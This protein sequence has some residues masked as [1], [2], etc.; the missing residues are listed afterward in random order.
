[1]AGIE[2]SDHLADEFHDWRDHS[3]DLAQVPVGTLSGTPPEDWAALPR[4]PLSY[5]TEPKTKAEL[6]AE[7]RATVKKAGAKAA[8]AK[9]PKPA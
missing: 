8:P 2:P 3:L 4:A 7:A 5:E 6:Q 9:A 1:M